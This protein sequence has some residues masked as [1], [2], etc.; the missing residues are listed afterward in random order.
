[1]FE[2]VTFLL[3]MI[4]YAG[5]TAT[6][7]VSAR[8][9]VP[10]GLW[11]AVA[12]IIVAHVALVWAV[13]YEWQLAQAVRNGYGGFVVFHGA[14]AII[15]L[16]LAT[17]DVVSRR[18]ILAAFLIVSA[19]AVAAVFRYEVVAIYRVPVV[20]CALGGVIGIAAAYRARVTRRGP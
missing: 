9:R 5:L 3:A 2:Q 14:L 16:S 19:G 1:M 15:V 20:L 18:L 4:G 7:V 13:R 6:A 17:P 10:A 8:G 11:R 12:A